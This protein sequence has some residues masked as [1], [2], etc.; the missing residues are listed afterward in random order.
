[1]GPALGPEFYRVL[2]QAVMPVS[3]I[4]WI[5]VKYELASEIWVVA[6]VRVTH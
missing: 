1:M 4:K 2:D 3:N 5:S 6:K